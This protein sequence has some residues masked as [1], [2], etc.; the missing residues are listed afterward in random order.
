ME[1]P[2][3]LITTRKQAKK[4]RNIQHVCR[5]W[6]TGNCLLHVTVNHGKPLII[7]KCEIVIHCI[8]K[9]CTLNLDIYVLLFGLKHV[10]TLYIIE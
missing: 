4:D 2:L 3:L 5:F 8:E 9:S 1:P 6:F 7:V 10:I